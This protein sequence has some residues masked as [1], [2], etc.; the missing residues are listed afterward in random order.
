MTL[1]V[2]DLLHQ[3]HNIIRMKRGI[4]VNGMKDDKES[5]EVGC[6]EE[7]KKKKET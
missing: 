1:R 2:A 6:D 4:Q 3:V 5:P 7:R